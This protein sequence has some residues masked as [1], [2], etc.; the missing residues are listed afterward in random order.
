MVLSAFDR[1]GEWKGSGHCARKIPMPHLL[2]DPR[3]KFLGIFSPGC[4]RS[5]S[6]VNLHIDLKPRSATSISCCCH[7]KW[8]GQIRSDREAPKNSHVILCAHRDRL[9]AYGTQVITF[10]MQNLSNI[11]FLF[12]F[13]TYHLAVFSRSQECLDLDRQFE[14]PR[15]S[16]FGL[17]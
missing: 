4:V 6:R 3:S 16:G 2:P 11:L 8:R 12:D 5:R 9:Y 17:N 1:P 7:L 15:A 13:S 10:D 14:K